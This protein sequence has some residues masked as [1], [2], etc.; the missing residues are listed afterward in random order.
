M[1]DQQV[2]ETKRGRVQI[3]VRGLGVGNNIKV[4]FSQAPLEEALLEKGKWLQ[5]SL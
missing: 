2:T 5:D 3:G 1:K 4:G